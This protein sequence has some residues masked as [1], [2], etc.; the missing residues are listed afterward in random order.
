MFSPIKS[1]CQIIAVGDKKWQV[2]TT[3]AQWGVARRKT[4]E[5]DKW[6]EF[7]GGLLRPRPSSRVFLSKKKK[8][9]RCGCDAGGRKRS[10]DIP[11]DHRGQPTRTY[12][13]ILERGP[14][15]WKLFHFFLK[16]KKGKFIKIKNSPGLGKMRMSKTCGKHNNN[17]NKKCYWNVAC[18]TRQRSRKQE[19]VSDEAGNG[20]DARPQ[21]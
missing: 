3:D 12:R 2:L 15:Q 10:K 14:F 20:S 17:N 18:F 6:M 21:F 11:L 4:N 9:I 19:N 13:S 5:L 8:K 16:E 1:K 7:L